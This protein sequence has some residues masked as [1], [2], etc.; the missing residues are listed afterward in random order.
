MR[1]IVI[2]AGNAQEAPTKSRRCRHIALDAVTITALGEHERRVRGRASQAGVRLWPGAFVFSHHPTGQRPWRPDSA[3]RALRALRA[4]VGLDTLR[5]HDLRHFVAT[6]L[7]TS[8][9]DVRTVSGRLGH[10]TTSTTLNVYAAFVPDA[11]RRAADVMGRLVTGQGGPCDPVGPAM[12]ANG[13]AN[14]RPTAKDRA[15]A[16]GFG[17]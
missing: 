11:D 4:E 13:S 5:L 8:G 7:L 2:V 3:S 14:G 9:I 1:S 15:G 12:S 6:R 17:G 16:S 10:S